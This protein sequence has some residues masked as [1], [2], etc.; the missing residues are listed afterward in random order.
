MDN[1]YNARVDLRNFT[2]FFSPQDMNH[3]PRLEDMYQVWRKNGLAMVALTACHTATDGIDHRFKFY[4]DQA[5]NLKDGLTGTVY[6]GGRFMTLEHQTDQIIPPLI[7]LNSQQIRTDFNGRPADLNVIGVANT[8][9][10]TRNLKETAKEARDQGG[11]VLLS[12]I[13]ENTGVSIGEAIALYAEGLVDGA[14][15][16]AYD[17][18]QDQLTL[19][20]SLQIGQARVPIVPVSGGHNYRQAGT[21]YVTVPSGEVFSSPAD[22]LKKSIASGKFRAHYGEIGRCSRIWNRDRHIL[23]SGIG[24]IRAGGQRRREFLKAVGLWK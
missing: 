21:S 22:H 1:V 15:V 4:A 7:V 23:A 24:H 11:L 19:A 14:E 2:H 10:P 8:I 12:H 17:S 13:E 3:P 20:T 5:G 6:D 9:Y 18:R 16:C